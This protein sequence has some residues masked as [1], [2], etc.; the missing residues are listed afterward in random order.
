MVI[1]W[2]RDPQAAALLGMADEWK[3]AGR[4]WGRTTTAPEVTCYQKPNQPLPPNLP[5]WGPGKAWH[6]TAAPAG[7]AWTPF[8]TAC[9]TPN[10]L[11]PTGQGVAKLILRTRAC[12][13]AKCR[14]IALQRDTRSRSSNVQGKAGPQ[15]GSRR[16]T[17]AAFPC[18]KHTRQRTLRSTGNTEDF[19]FYCISFGV[20]FSNITFSLF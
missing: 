18:F 1:Q 10:H 13:M 8:G 2:Q 19:P 16:S 9:L 3:V 5:C 17:T 20:S 6:P 7:L 12:P 15:L 11:H 4:R 14:R